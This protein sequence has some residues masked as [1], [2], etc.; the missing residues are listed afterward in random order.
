VKLEYKMLKEK[1]REFN[2]KDAQF[3]GKMFSKM[4][5]SNVSGKP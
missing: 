2:K 3:Y 5:D 1:M 4:L